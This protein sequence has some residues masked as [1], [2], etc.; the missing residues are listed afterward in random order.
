[1]DDQIITMDTYIQGDFFDDDDLIDAHDFLTNSYT[2]FLLKNPDDL[3]DLLNEF[4]HIIYVNF[5]KFKKRIPDNRLYT[6][7]NNVPDYVS[8]Y[9]IFDFYQYVET[10]HKCEYDYGNLEDAAFFYKEIMRIVDKTLKEKFMF[11]KIFTEKEKEKLIKK[12]K[13][14]RFEKQFFPDYYK[15]IHFHFDKDTLDNKKLDKIL[16]R[17][18]FG[19]GHG[20]EKYY[21][22]QNKFKYEDKM[23]RLHFYN[24]GDISFKDIWIAQ[25]IC[26]HGLYFITI[27]YENMTDNILHIRMRSKYSMFE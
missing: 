17:V 10:K 12:Y 16:D 3:N 14:S 15:G 21:I 2:L 4:L 8:P 27:D 5:G 11:G 26:K 13:K 22:K 18:C 1:M 20:Y 6:I 7:K 24:L 23:H 25:S 9:H 19:C